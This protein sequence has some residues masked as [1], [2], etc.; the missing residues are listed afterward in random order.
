MSST[1]VYISGRIRGRLV[2]MGCLSMLEKFAARVS[3]SVLIHHL[4]IQSFIQNYSFMLSPRC[5]WSST[6]TISYMYR[7]AFQHI[8]V[9]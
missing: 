9:K 6:V 2:K 1:M 3:H 7:F 8:D 5:P 4:Y